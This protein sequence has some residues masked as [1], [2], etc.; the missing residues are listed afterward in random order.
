LSPLEPTLTAD[1]EVISWIATSVSWSS[2]LGSKGFL[3]WDEFDTMIKTAYEDP[4]VLR[5]A[6]GV[7]RK[8]GSLSSIAR[9]SFFLITFLPSAFHQVFHTFFFCLTTTMV[10]IEIYLTK[11]P[12]GRGRVTPK[13]LGKF[14]KFADQG[15]RRLTAQDD[16]MRKKAGK[17]TKVVV[18]PEE[19]AAACDNELAG[20]VVTVPTKDLN[21]PEK[22]LKDL[23]KTDIAFYSSY[24]LCLRKMSEKPFTC[25]HRIALRQEERMLVMC[26]LE[27]N[28]DSHSKNRDYQRMACIVSIETAFVNSYRLNLLM[29]CPGACT[30]RDELRNY[31]DSITVVQLL[32]DLN[33]VGRSSDRITWAFP[34]WIETP[35]G[36][37][38][39]KIY[40]AKDM[41]QA[42]NKA[43]PNYVYRD[44]RSAAEKAMTSLL[45][46]KLLWS[47]DPGAETGAHETLA[48]HCLKGL[49]QVPPRFFATRT[50]L[51]HLD[52][53]LQRKTVGARKVKKR[54]S[55]GKPVQTEE[56]EDPPVSK[57]VHPYQ[58]GRFRT[59]REHAHPLELR[60]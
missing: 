25:N 12:V 39:S 27:W 24:T 34:D 32:S 47:S 4:I 46:N 1:L 3:S 45:K 57:R 59:F 15:E 2:T 53:V 35:E 41:R 13:S 51:T 40:N 50:S 31:F 19:E 36:D 26:G 28:L 37:H 30:L 44:K 8:V 54:G 14:K 10:E 6:S 55:K 23:G 18:D 11:N 42:L 22:I 20:S 33:R 52:H 5:S 58:D 21:D 49:W 29:A 16:L 43:N 56:R 7:R 17:K 9:S 60:P 38:A 48:Y